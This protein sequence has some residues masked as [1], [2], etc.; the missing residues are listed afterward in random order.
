MSNRA[1]FQGLDEF[2]K[3]TYDCDLK[4]CL[5]NQNERCI[6]NIAPINQEPTRVCHE[7][8]RMADIESMHDHM[9]Y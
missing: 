5:Y 6:Y 9:G 8:I 1:Y 7:D 2:A 3:G 4:A